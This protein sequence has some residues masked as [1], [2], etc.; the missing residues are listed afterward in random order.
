M[1]KR[2]GHYLGT[3]IEGKWWYR[4]TKTPFFARGNGEYWYDNQSFCFQRFLTQKTLVIP[5]R[6]IR[7]VQ[8]GRW[9]CGRWMWGIPIVKLI[10]EN[11][12]ILLSS[13]FIL[14]IKASEFRQYFDDLRRYISRSELKS[15]PLSDTGMTHICAGALTCHFLR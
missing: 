2:K 14:S 4:Y 13:G 15:S 12:G 3:E 5:F 11:N 1:E 6:H 8:I 7:K 10:W 9:H